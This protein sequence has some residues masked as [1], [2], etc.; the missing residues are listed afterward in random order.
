MTV[1]L[2]VDP[3]QPGRFAILGDEASVNDWVGRLRNAATDEDVFQLLADIDPKGDYDKAV[4]D[5]TRELDKYQEE[6][7]YTRRQAV[8]HWKQ[9][10]LVGIG[11][12]TYDA[13]HRF[14]A[15]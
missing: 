12:G 5:G 8:D 15:N 11:C 9:P 10:L 14:R 1:R 2:G 4:I 6:F 13:Q 3:D 7:G